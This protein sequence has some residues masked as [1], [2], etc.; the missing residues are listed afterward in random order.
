MPA[1]DE[2]SCFFF[3]L[4]LFVGCT[5]SLFAGS[6][7]PVSTTPHYVDPYYIRPCKSL[8]VHRVDSPLFVVC[9]HLMSYLAVE[10]PVSRS[11]CLDLVDMCRVASWERVVCTLIFWLLGGWGVSGMVRIQ[12]DI[13]LRVGW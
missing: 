9:R 12:G 7:G 10:L 1:L 5:W 13:D 8:V 3:R 11:C 2:F 4:A 6:L